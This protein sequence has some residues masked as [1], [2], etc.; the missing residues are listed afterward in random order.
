MYLKIFLKNYVIIRSD[1]SP[2]DD[3]LTAIKQNL[4]NWG[5]NVIREMN[6]IGMLIDISHV[7]HGVMHAVLDVTEAPVIFSH[8]SSFTVKNHHRNVKDD[9]LRRLKINDGII[10]VNFYTVFIGGNESITDVI[11]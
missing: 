9:V 7:S 10:M 8:S 3:N 11:S 6:R 2:F 1:A 5:T 4:T